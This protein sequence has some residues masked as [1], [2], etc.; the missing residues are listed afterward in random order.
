MIQIMIANNLEGILIYSNMLRR[1]NLRYF[2]DFNPLEPDAMTLFTS[3]G[4]AVLL[5]PIDTEETR[6]KASSWVRKVISFDGNLSHICDEMMNMK[7]KKKLGIAGWE[8]IPTDMVLEIKSAFPDIELMDVTSA[9]HQIR[10]MKSEAEIRKIEK[11]AEIADAAFEYLIQ[12]LRPGIKEYEIIAMAEYK[13]RQLGGEDNFQLL[14]SSKGDMRAMHPASDR[15]LE[16]GD[17]FLTEI[18]PQFD[19][20]YA[21]VCRTVVIGKIS[22]QRQKAHDILFRAQQKGIENVRPGMT[23][24]DLAKIQNDVFREEG[25]GE[26]V[27]EKYTRGRGHGI[28]LYIDEEPLVA[29]GNDYEL[30]ENMVLMIHPNTYLPLSGYIVLGDPVLITKEGGRR[31]SHSGRKLMAVQ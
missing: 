10:A 15:S 1:E 4:S 18:S 19:G 28:G 23:A 8:Y 3:E 13:I 2:T 6:A 26:Y 27:S 20:Y 25:F 17:I 11:A 9:V 22:E 14:A 12:N 7:V 24:S 29:E 5:L 31:L 30:K 16:H 21:Q